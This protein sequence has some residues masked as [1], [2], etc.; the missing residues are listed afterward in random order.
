MIRKNM[1]GSYRGLFEVLPVIWPKRLTKTTRN[2]SQENKSLG[3]RTCN[4]DY[5]EVSDDNAQ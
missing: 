4:M 3:E 5:T 1:D 2:L